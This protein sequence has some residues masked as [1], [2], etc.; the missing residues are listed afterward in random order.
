MRPP[1]S[2][3]FATAS[4]DDRM[5]MCVGPSSAESGLLFPSKPIALTDVR[6]DRLEKLESIVSSF[7]AA[8]GRTAGY[9]YDR[10]SFLRGN[11]SPTWVP[12]LD[13]LVEGGWAGS[14]VIEVA[15]GK[16]VGKTLVSISRLGASRRPAH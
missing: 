12:G 4:L 1:G 8:P 11:L 7:L 3:G 10:A 14:D 2:T 9:L 16:G 5:L 6:P 13:E 15:G